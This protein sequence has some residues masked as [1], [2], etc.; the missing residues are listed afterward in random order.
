MAAHFS[1]AL[2]R[3]EFLES[4]YWQGKLASS[5]RLS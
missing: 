5:G 3:L 2:S 1:L 4:G